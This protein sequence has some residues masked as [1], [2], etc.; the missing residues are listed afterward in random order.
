MEG[1][2]ETQKTKPFLNTLADKRGFQVL[3]ST[4]GLKKKS[5]A[6]ED[7]V[8]IQGRRGSQPLKDQRR[9]LL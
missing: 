7:T 6:I 3:V 1:K 8:E 4:L 5:N 9:Y 2:K